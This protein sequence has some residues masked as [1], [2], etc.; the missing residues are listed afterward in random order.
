MTQTIEQAIVQLV[1]IEKTG[2]SQ[3]QVDG[4]TV[5]AEQEGDRVRVVDSRVVLAPTSIESPA[6]RTT[7][8]SGWRRNGGWPCPGASTPWCTSR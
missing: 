4:I 5:V 7:M 6:S 3:E 2:A 1:E 8:A